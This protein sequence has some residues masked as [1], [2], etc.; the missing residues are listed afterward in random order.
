MTSITG[1]NREE[2]A[3]GLSYEECMA[4]RE[5]VLADLNTRRTDVPPTYP[6]MRCPTSLSEGIELEPT[7][8]STAQP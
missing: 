7:G 8:Y 4:E 6:V 1:L 5:F 2:I 3:T